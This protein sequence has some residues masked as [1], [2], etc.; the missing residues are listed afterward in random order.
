MT[1]KIEAHIKDLDNCIVVIG[2]RMFNLKHL[3]LICY[4]QPLLIYAFRIQ[5]N[6]ANICVAIRDKVII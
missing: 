6:R 3:S 2:S 4:I 1:T 5:S